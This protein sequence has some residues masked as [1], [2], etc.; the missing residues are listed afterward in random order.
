MYSSSKS[1]LPGLALSLCAVSF[2]PLATTAEIDEPPS[3]NSG[4]FYD[5]FELMLPSKI[6]DPKAGGDLKNNE[7]LFFLDF[8][9]SDEYGD[10][11]EREILILA[12]EK[13]VLEDEF[14][15]KSGIVLYGEIKEIGGISDLTDSAVSVPVVPFY[16]QIDDIDWVD[17]RSK[18][19]GVVGLAMIINYYFPDKTTPQQLLEEGLNAGHFLNGV[20]WKHMGLA[21]MA[22]D[23]GLDGK[24]YDYLSYDMDFAYERLLEYLEKGPVI[25]SVFHSFDP[26]S[27]IP[28]LAVVNGIKNDV[29]YYND[30][31]EK[32]GGGSISVRDFQRGWKK[33]FIAIYE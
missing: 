23:H 30:P 19:C 10:K 28:H 15:E 3:I 22:Q 18:A 31:A 26:Q 12:E 7:N 1:I 4:G 16:S 11:E 5:K 2:S 25:V 24:S 17:W 21:L 14:L 29:V 33:R 8:V 20:G 27:P 6:S 13:I 9:S 32:F